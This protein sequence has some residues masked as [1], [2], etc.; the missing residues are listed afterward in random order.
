MRRYWDAW[1]IFQSK[2]AS[3][4]A[5]LRFG[6][7][8]I[9]RLM[10]T[11]FQVHDCIYNVPSLFSLSFSIET[12]RSCR[13]TC[14]EAVAESTMIWC[15]RQECVEVCHDDL[16]SGH[17]CKIQNDTHLAIIVHM[18][19]STASSLKPSSHYGV[20]Y[21][22]VEPILAFHN[23]QRLVLWE[24][25]WGL[26]NVY[27]IT[28]QQAQMLSSLQA[29]KHLVIPINILPQF[30]AQ[31]NKQHCQYSEVILMSCSLE[32]DKIALL[33]NRLDLISVQSF[34]TWAAF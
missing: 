23:L 11:T 15:L 3:H 28:S 19:A 21:A 14:A 5:H 25:T 24:P 1:R 32:T 27:K 33:Y 6:S 10:I 20:F 13:T 4:W 17:I 30:P 34:W 7:I 12:V 22:G 16:P 2:T 31:F 9:V 29:L 18:W 26:T 8:G